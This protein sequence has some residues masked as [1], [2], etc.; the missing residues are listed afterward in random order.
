MMRA[1]FTAAWCRLLEVEDC[2]ADSPEQYVELALRL[3]HDR[4]FAAGVKNRIRK[5]CHRLFDD[6]SSVREFEDFFE[7]AY[8]AA[9]GAA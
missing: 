7:S 5:N 8:A 2:I 1:R 3:A 9:A 6:E 4:E